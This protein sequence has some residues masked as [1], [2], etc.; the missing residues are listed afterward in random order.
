M[1]LKSILTAF[2]LLGALG[3]AGAAMAETDATSGTSPGGEGISFVAN[4]AGYAGNLPVTGWAYNDGS[5]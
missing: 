5:R 1:S 2:A 3:L 4:G